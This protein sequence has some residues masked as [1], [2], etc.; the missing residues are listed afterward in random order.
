M[1]GRSGDTNQ[2]N[3]CLP[4]NWLNTDVLEKAPPELSKKGDSPSEQFSCEK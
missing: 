2:T 1:A 3:G 4:S